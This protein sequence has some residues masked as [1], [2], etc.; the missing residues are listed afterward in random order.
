MISW[1]AARCDPAHYGRLVLFQFPKQRLIYGPRQIEARIDQDPA[2]S[3]LITLWSQAG[4][5]VVR[6]N[7]LV[8]PVAN[9]LL[10]VEPLYLQAETSQLPELKRVI[11]AY[12]SRIAMEPTLDAALRRVFAPKREAPR[13]EVV[14]APT[15]AAPP[16]AAEGAAPE[17][18]EAAAQLGPAERAH[19]VYLEA[20]ERL[21]AGDWAGYGASVEELGRLLEELAGASEQQ[22]NPVE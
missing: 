22:R 5:R 2:I 10:Y 17:A 9:S 11:V 7:L 8:I 4:S 6:G 1:M 15:E 14:V 19:G 21:R 3:Q 12:E 20:Q 13:A 16:G 18:E